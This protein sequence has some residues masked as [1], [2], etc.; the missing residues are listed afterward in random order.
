MSRIQLKHTIWIVF[1]IFTFNFILKFL[2][3]DSAPIGGDE[4]FSIF[5]SQT[6]FRTLLELSKNEN[7]PPFF[8]LLLKLWTGYFGISPISVRF[9]PLIFSSL[10]AVFIYTFMRELTNIQFG[11]IASGIFTFSNYHIYFSHEARPYALFGLLTILALYY[12]LR[13]LKSSQRRWLVLLT[14]TNVLL[15]YNHFF[16]FFVLMIEFFMLTIL[17]IE[18]KNWRSIIKSWIITTLC[19]LPYLPFLLMRFM[20]SSKGGTWL[21]VPKP[22]ELYSIF[23]KFSNEPVVAGFGL[24]LLL[25]GI[26][27]NRL[28]WKDRNFLFLIVSLFIPLIIIFLI[29]QVIPM[30]LDRYFV[31]LGVI[32]ILALSYFFYKLQMPLAKYSV[33]SLILLGF[34]LTVNLGEGNDEPDDKLVEVLQ[35]QRARD[36]QV[37]IAPPYYQYNFVYHYDRTLLTN[38]LT[39]WDDLKD[40]HISVIQNTEQ[41]REIVLTDTCFFLAKG[42]DSNMDLKDIQLSL[43][44]LYSTET[45]YFSNKANILIKY[46]GLVDVK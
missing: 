22:Q 26:A 25:G 8:T 30:F 21:T 28:V 7:N 10:T 3:I 27:L 12:T 31:Y 29:S 32:Y 35:N 42:I 4:P 18:K 9:M 38:P 6:D 2:F 23:V 37:I 40:Q 36:E 16:G 43:K 45:V 44:Q 33:S 46:T 13:S 14:I 24:L 5:F 20:E 39:C 41:L 15:I 19:Y 11:L 34:I 1:G 17:P